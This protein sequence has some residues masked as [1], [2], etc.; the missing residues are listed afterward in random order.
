[1]ATIRYIYNFAQFVLKL[2]Q[3]AIYLLFFW[4]YLNE[5]MKLQF[6]LSVSHVG[7]LGRLFC[8]R[9]RLNTLRSCNIYAKKEKKKSNL[10]FS[11]F[12]RCWK[13]VFRK[14]S[15]KRQ[16]LA[17]MGGENFNG[18][19]DKSGGWWHWNWLKRLT[20]LNSKLLQIC[21]QEKHKS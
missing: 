21:F 12:G 11:Q 1:M 14:V 19:K 13:A 18:S 16:F 17:V 7:P 4:V 6:G 3:F 9:A 8:F 2:I 5:Q 10:S 20:N 15:G